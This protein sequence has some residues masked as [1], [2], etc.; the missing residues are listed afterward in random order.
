MSHFASI[1]FARASLRF[2]GHQ[3]DNNNDNS[4]KRP[5]NDYLAI[6]THAADGRRCYVTFVAVCESVRLPALFVCLF[7][8]CVYVKIVKSA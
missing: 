6:I 8:M 1:S 2:V 3:L 5:R 4:K 7:G